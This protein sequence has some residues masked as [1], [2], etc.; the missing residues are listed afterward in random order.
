MPFIINCNRAPLMPGVR[1]LRLC[2]VVFMTS[3]RF[4]LPVLCG[5][6]AAPV[7]WVVGVYLFALSRSI[8]PLVLFFPY[9]AALSPLVEDATLLGTA[10]IPLSVVLQYPL[11]GIAVGI[12]RVRGHAHGVAVALALA[13][14]IFAVIGVAVGKN[15]GFL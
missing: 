6:V 2:G 12:A 11:Y 13:H 4:W 7:C 10:V 1:L 14:M 15:L 5:V 3:R 9:W 8:Y